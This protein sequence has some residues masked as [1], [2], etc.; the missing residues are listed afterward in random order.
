MEKM[1][2][3]KLRNA[4]LYKALDS[5]IIHALPG[6]CAASIMHRAY[7]IS[8]SQRVVLTVTNC[9]YFEEAGIELLKYLISADA[10]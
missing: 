3:K 9:T 10:N 5:F 8:I 7:S 1:N 2:K 4:Y 6:G